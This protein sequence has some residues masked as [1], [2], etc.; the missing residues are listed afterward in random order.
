MK[1]YFFI[2]ALSS[3]IANASTIIGSPT[4]E[5]NQEGLYLIKIKIVSDSKISEDQILITNFKSD[6][7]LSD[8][9]F[10]Y[11]IFESLPDFKRLTL[12]LSREHLEDYI[13]F[14]IN[15]QEELKKDIFIFLPQN[16]KAG[17]KK[18]NI[19]FKLPAKKIYGEP[20]RYDIEK[21]LSEESEYTNSN[22]FEP[23]SL[24]SVKK[25]DEREDI[26]DSLDIIP[27]EEIETIWS[28]SSSVS[29]NFEASIYQIMWG[30]YLENPNAF[31]DDNIN[32][33][34]GDID[35]SIPSQEL[36]AST[37][38]LNA[39]NSIAFM[40]SNRELVK[41]FEEKPTLK[42]TAPTEILNDSQN[43]ESINSNSLSDLDSIQIAE[44]DNSKLS[45]SEIV[46]KN[47]SIIDLQTQGN[48]SSEKLASNSS[49]S[50]S[51]QDLLW[52]GILSLMIGFATAY[53]LIRH[54]K[55][56]VF[57]KEML[58]E[59]LLDENNI[60]QS[61]L[62]ISNDIETQELDLVRTYIDMGDKESATKIIDKIIANSSNDYIISEARLLKKQNNKL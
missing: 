5:I 9:K 42:L 49:Q 16:E 4:V 3:F 33:V 56:T 48:F 31:I 54:T 43:R 25:T 50:F 2:L 44:I 14:R 55:K 11:R 46:K 26:Q 20:K 27:G 30:F 53:F 13:S 1:K 18:S 40:N 62:S 7:E 17:I 28:V 6:D 21:I 58:E 35:L 34:R 45:G 10:E 12:S 57:L 59:D 15:I 29:K 47:T 32:M 19:S 41:R 39:R 37:S 36:V 24:F 38:D 52:V 60:F 61:N 8:F 22:Q 23:N 51:I